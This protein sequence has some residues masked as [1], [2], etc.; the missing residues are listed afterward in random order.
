M[1]SAQIAITC[2]VNHLLKESLLSDQEQEIQKQNNER[3]SI[4]LY[5]IIKKYLNNNQEIKEKF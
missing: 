2:W 4:T 5:D 1:N 3:F